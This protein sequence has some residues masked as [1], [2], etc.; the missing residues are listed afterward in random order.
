MKMRKTK[1]KIH[2]AVTG[3]HDDCRY[4]PNNGAGMGNYPKASNV[5]VDGGKK[6]LQ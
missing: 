2:V 3:G 4:A 5:F 6:L 1:N